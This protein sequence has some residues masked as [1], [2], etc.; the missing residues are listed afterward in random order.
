MQNINMRLRVD[1]VTTQLIDD[2]DQPISKIPAFVRGMQCNLVLELVDSS[3]L[4]LE[5]LNYTCWDFVLA[6]DWLTSTE[7]QLHVS[8]GITTDGNRVIIP[9][10]ETD[11]PLL[12]A[13]LGN[14]E[15]I[16]LGGELA[17][18]DAESESPSF[19]I[20]FSLK[21][22]NR[23]GTTRPENS[24]SDFPFTIVNRFELENTTPE[25]LP[26]GKYKL[27]MFAV[28]PAAVSVQIGEAVFEESEDPVNGLR[29]FKENNAIYLEKQG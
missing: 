1:S 16:T 3:I 29:V 12:E 23:R 14:Q 9:L 8:E 7:A 13:K 17:G 10:L 22:R 11:N 20:Q 26:V 5:N 6:D 15:E 27:G 21:V 25:T 24:V 4:P 28:A 2:G 18:F 19:L